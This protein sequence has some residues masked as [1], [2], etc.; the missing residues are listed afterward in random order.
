MKLEDVLGRCR[1]AG[2]VLRVGQDSRILASPAERLTDSMRALIREH[3]PVLLAALANT[4]TDCM[5]CAN[6]RMRVEHHDGSRRRFWWRCE[7]GYELL[8][9]RH[10]GGRVLLAPPACDA[11][12]GFEPWKPGEP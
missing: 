9:G 1:T 4:G 12:R 5:S 10:Y 11:A 6:L 3:K 8:E 2:I 7:K